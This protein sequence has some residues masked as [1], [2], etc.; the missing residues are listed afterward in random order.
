MSG[1]FAFA[2]RHADPQLLTRTVFGAAQQ[3]PFGHGW[4][5]CTGRPDQG[6]RHQLHIERHPRDLPDSL[7]TILAQAMTM[8][9]GV[10]LGH[11]REKISREPLQPLVADRYAIA[12]HGLISNPWELWPGSDDIP[13]TEAFLRAYDV[14][15]RNGTP[16]AQALEV[17][18]YITEQDKGLFA[19]ADSGQLL[20]HHS[21][22]SLFTYTN[23][24]SGTYL[25]GEAMHPDAEPLASDRVHVFTAPEAQ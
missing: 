21:G 20:V 3:G 19:I 9:G 17:L 12:H 23:P 10:L 14:H 22:M 6:E 4:V 7:T 5:V 15:R 13:G 24:L 18:T 8:T 25:G 11:T 2:G 1:I 16:A